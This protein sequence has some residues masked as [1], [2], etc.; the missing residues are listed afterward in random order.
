MVVELSG[1]RLI[2]TGR[3]NEPPDTSSSI[4]GAYVAVEVA[5]LPMAM[6]AA[7]ASSSVIVTVDKRPCELR[8]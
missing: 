7:S 2:V 5:L 4:S 6:R 3:L 1:A 8:V